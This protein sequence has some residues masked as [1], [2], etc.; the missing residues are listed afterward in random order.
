VSETAELKLTQRDQ[1]VLKEL[2]DPGN[3]L[4]VV[5]PDDTAPDVLIKNLTIC[6]RAVAYLKSYA[7]RIKPIIG[8]ILTLIQEHPDAYKKAGY[9]G[10]ESFIRGEVIG[11]MGLCRTDVYDCVKIHKAMPSLTPAQFQ[12][13]GI[14]KLRLLASITGDGQPSCDRWK[15]KA[16]SMTLVEFRTEAEKHGLVAKGEYQGAVIVINTNTATSKQWKEFISNPEIQAH[17]G[18]ADGGVILACLMAE[19]L[20]TWLAADQ[21]AQRSRK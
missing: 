10:Y 13:I 6:C 8:R 19:G 11:K 15:A 16:R 21:D 9:E 7:E 1:A 17:V 5:L 4:G 12:E 20:S 2:L 3:T 18:T 14:A